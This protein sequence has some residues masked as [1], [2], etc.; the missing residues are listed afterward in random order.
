MRVKNREMLKVTNYLIMGEVIN[1]MEHKDF[2]H[3]T[4]L[5]LPILNLNDGDHNQFPFYLCCCKKKNEKKTPTFGMEDQT[6]IFS[7][8]EVEDRIEHE[9]V[10]KS[11]DK[12]DDI[13]KHLMI[14]ILVKMLRSQ[15]REIR[16]I[17]VQLI[18]CI[19][20]KAIRNKK[21]MDSQWY[22]PLSWRRNK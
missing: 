6:A 10:V 22:C 19:G 8:G 9:E 21:W 2:C 13:S 1:L 11:W 12:Y 3:I 5:V 7:L 4:E 20:K 15:N 16:N 17:S 14:I 18:V